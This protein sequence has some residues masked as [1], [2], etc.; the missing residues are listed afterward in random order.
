ML[1]VII[2][3]VVLFN[4][5]YHRFSNISSAGNSHQCRI[6]RK[7]NSVRVRTFSTM[8]TQVV[9]LQVYPAPKK[10]LFGTL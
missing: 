7:V 5:Q 8:K 6:C 10:S 2:K 4:Y 9:F 3:S 1:S